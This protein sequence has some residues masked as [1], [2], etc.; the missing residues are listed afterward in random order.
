MHGILRELD[1]RFLVGNTTGCVIKFIDRGFP[2][3]CY[4]ASG[5]QL[6]IIVIDHIEVV[7][8]RLSVY[9]FAGRIGK[10]LEAVGERSISLGF[11]AYGKQ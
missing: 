8:S 4:G 6:P 5:R 9:H 11:T 1:S 3:G 10:G 7:G 2:A